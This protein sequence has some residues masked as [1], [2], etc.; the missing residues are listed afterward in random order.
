MGSAGNRESKEM[1][2]E[3]IEAIHKQANIKNVKKVVQWSEKVVDK[4]R[5][6]KWIKSLLE[7]SQVDPWITDCAA[8]NNGNDLCPSLYP[9]S[10]EL[11]VPRAVLKALRYTR[12]SSDTF[13]GIVSKYRVPP[14]I[15]VVMTFAVAGNFSEY[16]PTG[17][18]SFACD[19]HPSIVRAFRKTT[20]PAD[21]E[22]L[23][24]F[25]G[26][27]GLGEITDCG[28]SHEVYNMLNKHHDE[29]DIRK[30]VQEEDRLQMQWTLE[31][32]LEA[33]EDEKYAVA[34]GKLYLLI[35]FM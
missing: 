26:L 3:E 22:V 32:A 23:A 27:E 19:V 24:D 25:Y 28:D 16:L 5:N 10:F 29:A 30:E 31:M 8:N 12:R 15:A 17:N 35:V 1:T 2:I 21:Y 20:F 7:E 34:E 14:H 33:D 18:L 11:V 9:P 13:Q 4:P 6:E